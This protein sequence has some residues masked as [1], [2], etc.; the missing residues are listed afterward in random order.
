VLRRPT[1]PSQSD[2]FRAEQD[3]PLLPLRREQS[4]SFKNETQKVMNTTENL[5][6]TQPELL[7]VQPLNQ[8][9]KPVKFP[10][11]P[12][13]WKIISLRECPT[14]EAMQLCDNPELAVSYW[15]THVQKHPYFKIDVSYY[16]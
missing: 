16:S 2:A 8:P 5:L 6:A 3:C 12:Q 1:A 4:R 11:Q 15:R 13:E 14:P 10:S 7:P 9:V